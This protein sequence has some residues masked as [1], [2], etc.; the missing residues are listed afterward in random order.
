MQNQNWKKRTQKEVDQEQY[1]RPEL[2][3]HWRSGPLYCYRVKWNE[4]SRHFLRDLDTH[5]QGWRQLNQPQPGPGR[6]ATHEPCPPLTEDVD[7]I[8]E[9]GSGLK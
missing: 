7:E 4:N 9:T 6:P 3:Q 1:V 8:P 5:F 2:A